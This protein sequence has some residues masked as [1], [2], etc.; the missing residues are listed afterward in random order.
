V[1]KS[2]S[3]VYHKGDI[4]EYLLRRKNFHVYILTELET[5]KPLLTLSLRIS[6]EIPY[7]LNKI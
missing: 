4:Y 6:N 5:I 2:V 7:M 3:I 1:I